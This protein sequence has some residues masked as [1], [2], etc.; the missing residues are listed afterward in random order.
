MVTKKPSQI[1]RSVSLFFIFVFILTFSTTQ[2]QAIPGTG[3][4]GVIEE[5][6]SPIPNYGDFLASV[7]NGD[8]SLGCLRS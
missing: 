8:A 2:I 4:T 7:R 3:Q 6:T 5:S 1:I